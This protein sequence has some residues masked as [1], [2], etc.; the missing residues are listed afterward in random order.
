[1]FFPSHYLTDQWH[2]AFVLFRNIYFGTILKQPPHMG[3]TTG[4]HPWEQDP[5]VDIRVY[6]VHPEQFSQPA[7]QCPNKTVH[8]V[9]G[10]EAGAGN[11]T[12]RSD[13]PTQ[14]FRTERE[15]TAACLSRG[16]VGRRLSL[17]RTEFNF[18]DHYCWF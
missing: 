8:L 6:S 9:P 15:D 7:R 13:C 17:S 11:E 14:L 4:P 3:K 10:S 1:M 2:L 12:I 16:K 18:I 5:G